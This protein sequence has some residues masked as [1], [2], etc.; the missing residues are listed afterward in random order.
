MVCNES[1][2]GSQKI[3]ILLSSGTN[4]R[5]SS[6]NPIMYAS[7]TE[8]PDWSGFRIDP[9]MYYSTKSGEV[10]LNTAEYSVE[11]ITTIL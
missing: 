10:V 5:K 4:T 11:W 8:Q 2:S 3:I 7:M 6:L 9:N 1:G